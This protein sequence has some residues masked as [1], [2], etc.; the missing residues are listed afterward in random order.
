MKKKF[1]LL[2]TFILIISMIPVYGAKVGDKLGDVLNTDIKVY[3]NEIQIMGYNI[4]GWTY[5]IAEDLKPYGFTVIWD[6]VAKSLSITQGPATGTA[7]PVPTNTNRVGSVAFPY[8]YTDIVT[9]IDGKIVKSYNIQGYTVIQTD[10]LA[11]AF[12][13][14]SWDGVKREL[15]LRTFTSISGRIIG[16]D[17][18]NG[19]SATVTLKDSAGTI[20]GTTATSTN[21]SYQFT[22]LIPGMYR[23]EASATGYSMNSTDLFSA[24]SNVTNRNLTLSRAMFTVSGRVYASD[25]PTG[26]SSTVKLIN[27]N[28]VTFD[29]KQTGST[30]SYLFTDVP[31]GTYTIEA[32]AQGYVAKTLAAFAVNGNVSNKDV[33]LERSAY[34]ISG[35]I[36]DKSS[37]SPI[38]A[39]TIQLRNTNNQI[40]DSRF[41]NS[42]GEYTFSS[43][44]PG[45]Y[46]MIVAKDGYITGTIPQFNLNENVTRNLELQK[47]GHTVSGSIYNTSGNNDTYTVKLVDMSGVTVDSQ[48]IAVQNNQTV[49]YSLT[50]AI[51][52]SYRIEVFGSAPSINAAYVGQYFYIN[53]NYTVPRIEIQGT[54]T[55][56]G[57][58]VDN[59]GAAVSNATV[60]LVGDAITSQI[61]STSSTG[62]YAFTNIPQGTY[63]VIASSSNLHSSSQPFEVSRNT[64]AGNSR[65]VT[66]SNIVL[67]M[68]T[69]HTVDIE[70]VS[71]G[72][73]TNVLNATIVLQNMGTNTEYKNFVNIGNI[74][75]FAN[76]PAGLYRI[77]VTAPPSSSYLNN[78]DILIDVGAGTPNTKTV[79]LQVSVS[80]T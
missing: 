25:A 10:D 20:R 40:V 75:R 76:I 80:P 13:S 52:N 53:G 58:V 14:A 9:Y 65:T 29:T 30:G 78:N 24:L 71:A 17:A 70:V 50:G 41:T 32:S 63:Y 48:T 34:T 73:Y 77:Y 4:D 54:F 35:K 16:S 2:L 18:P 22:G 38:A 3:I 12:G 19:I 66:V 61:Q 64:A 49:N 21:G 72:T 15:R 51:T 39:V 1:A 57:R 56:T 6:G 67:Q 26:V 28:G 69:A 79:T 42:N 33:L 5:V 44:T 23:I 46:T 45:Y 55:V 59:T 8:V 43:V 36:T 7:K 68:V 62:S 11:S 37:G 47:T 31:N 27:S 74:Y 60:V